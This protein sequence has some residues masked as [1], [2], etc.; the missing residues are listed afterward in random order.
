MAPKVKAFTCIDDSVYN[1]RKMQA[2]YEW[3]L[4]GNTWKDSGATS[5]MPK[6]D[7]EAMQVAFQKC[8][9][10]MSAYFSQVCGAFRNSSGNFGTEFW[11][12]YASNKGT[13]LK[14]HNNFKLPFRAES[15]ALFA[16]QTKC[17]EIVKNILVNAMETARNPHFLKLSPAYLAWEAGVVQDETSPGSF[18]AVVNV[19]HQ[20]EKIV[21]WQLTLRQE[22]SSIY[23]S[24]WSGDYEK[25]TATVEISVGVYFIQ[26]FGRYAPLEN[27]SILSTGCTCD[28]SRGPAMTLSLSQVTTI[29]ASNNRDTVDVPNISLQNTMH[30][31]LSFDP[32]QGSAVP[33]NHLR[34][35][36]NPPSP[37]SYTAGTIT[38]LD[39]ASTVPPTYATREPASP[40][41]CYGIS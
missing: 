12:F 11:E 35:E 33:F 30:L 3:R 1:T 21:C 17:Q 37:T 24:S 31:T 28:D 32:Y 6:L 4:R 41:Y 34:T 40:P 22:F 27:G 19:K 2:P 39:G 25:R 7:E 18:N 38:E 10:E 29:F 23:G 15:P 16:Q 8:G 26:A 36:S 5:R 14:N 20:E 9:D 13:N